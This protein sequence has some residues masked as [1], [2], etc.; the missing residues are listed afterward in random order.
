M[1]TYKTKLIFESQKVKDFWKKQMCLVRDCYNF[2]S[3]IVFEEKITLNIKLYHARLYRAER[4]AFPAL[5]A[6]M[7]IK[8]YKQVLA[9]YRT[10][11]ENK[12]ELSKP[13]EMKRPS[14]GLDKRL[15][16]RMTRES[17]CLSNGDGN[18]RLEVKFVLYPKFNEMAAKYKMCD[19]VLQYDERAD[20]FY[21]CIPFLAIETTPCPEKYLGVDLGIKRIATLSDGTA[22]TDKAYLARRRRIR[23]NKR[24]FQRH[25][26]QSH[27]ARRKLKRIRRKEYNYSKQFCHR[28]AIEILSHSGSVIV[29]EDLSKIKQTTSKTKEGFKKKR[30]NNM[31]SQVPFFQ[32]KQ[33][34]TYKAPLLGKR[35][36]TVSPQYTSQ[37]DCRTKSKEGCTRKG[38]RLYTAD[39]KVFDA[40]WNAA[41]N[42][43]N[44]KHPTPFGL[45]LD[46]MLNFVGRHRQ[47]VDSRKGQ[48]A[49]QAAMSS[50]WQ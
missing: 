28:I 33:I 8:V 47:Q 2:A 16:S 45:P 7:C 11:R 29:M 20:T 48:P 4:E 22:I 44:R 36:E 35:V 25:K 39:G 18:R 12:M 34:L 21:A 43:A 14:I 23:H 40:D 3:K 13:L 49:L 15:Y 30:H 46:G 38:C 42:I 41:I 24:I 6:Q 5:P 9:N 27:S 10:A 32:L 50:A 17:F 37:M 19:P 1:L 26:S 31:M